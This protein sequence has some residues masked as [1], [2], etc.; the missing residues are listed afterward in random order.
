MFCESCGASVSDTAKFCSGCGNSI[1]K[2]Q[3]SDNASHSDEWI[4]CVKCGLR[5]KP[6]STSCIRCNEPVKQ[7]LATLSI[8]AKPPLSSKRIWQTPFQFIIFIILIVIMLVASYSSLTSFFHDLFTA[9]IG[10]SEATKSTSGDVL[11]GEKGRLNDGGTG[12]IPVCVS[13]EAL[14]KMTDAAAAHDNQGAE[15]LI[16][17]GEVFMV[18]ENTK[19]LEIDEGGF[20][21]SVRKVR[22]LDGNW[23]GRAVWVPYEWVKPPEKKAP[24]VKMKS[25]AALPS[26]N[27]YNSASN[28]ANVVLFPVGVNGKWGYINR[29]GKLVIPLHFDIAYNFHEGLAPVVE[30]NYKYGYIN[31]SGKL[32]IPPQYDAADNFRE[33]LALVG[34]NAKYGYINTSGKLVIPLQYDYAG[35]FYEGLARVVVNNEFGYIN[36]SGNFVIQP[37]HF[38]IAYNFHEGLAMVEVNG[39]WG[40][41]NR[42][43]KLVIPPPFQYAEKFREGLALVGVNAKY[44]YINTSGKWVWKPTK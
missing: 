44:G 23:K 3:L 33:G 18:P 42:S 43:G 8:E 1:A 22:I 21:A 16:A 13:K 25:S 4:S 19:I 28:S 17:S 24:P 35:Y 31:K 32:V 27:S 9:T 5:L 12:W 14:D 34:V 36:K 15:N 10:K 38:D 37:Q 20:L 41:I 40:Y 39:K 2:A 7:P 30:V 26:L 11:I 29:S 6:D